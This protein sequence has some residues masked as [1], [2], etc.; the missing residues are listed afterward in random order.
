MDLTE[1]LIQKSI[2]LRRCFTPP[3]CRWWRTAAC[4]HCFQPL[5]RE[6]RLYQAD[7]LLR[8]YHSTAQEL[9][10][11]EEPLLTPTRDPKCTWAVRH[12]AFSRWRSTPPA[13][14][15]C[16]GCP[17]HRPQKRMRI[18]AAR[19]V[20][21]NLGMAELKRIGVVLESG[22]SIFITCRGK[23]VAHANRA[24]IARALLDPKAFSVGMQQL[25]LDD[26]VA[27]GAAGC[28]PG[29]AKAGRPR[30]GGGYSRKNRA[31]GGAAMS[32]QAHV[33]DVAYCYDGSF[34]GFL[35]C[36][37][38]SYAWQRDPRRSGT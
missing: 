10:T 3:I 21:R 22:R 18:L 5:L 16:C 15:N 34:A 23:A 13:R 11:E 2:A 30:H 17:G 26:F 29:R 4:R 19:G 12:P 38:E 20:C 8:Y 6:H 27:Q 24:E 33:T 28:C 14:R 35:C 1:G 7:W 36:V 32:Y 9:L 25:S 37:F 31:A